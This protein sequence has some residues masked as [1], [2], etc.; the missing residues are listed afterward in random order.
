MKG[1]TLLRSNGGYW[2][3]H[4]TALSKPGQ[5]TLGRRA[6][7][8]IRGAK[9]QWVGPL[10]EGLERSH[11]SVSLDEGQRG[12]PLETCFFRFTPRRILIFSHTRDT[13]YRSTVD[14]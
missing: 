6:V 3:D 12:T 1:G 5:T 14:R 7:A 11:T 9:Q 8:T 2:S 4:A 13:F 10:Q